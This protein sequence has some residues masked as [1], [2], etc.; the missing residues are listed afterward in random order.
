MWR[1][2]LSLLVLQNIITLDSKAQLLVGP[3]L[4]GEVSKAFF[5]DNQFRYKSLPSFGYEGG[6]MASMRVRKNFVLNAQLLYSHRSKHI[7]GKNNSRSDNLFN[8]TSSMQYLELPI[9]YVLEFKTL[10]G[11][12]TG[13]G[14]RVKTYNWFIGGGPIISYWL[15]NKGTLRSSPLKEVYI[16]HIDYTTVFGKDNNSFTAGS[17]F[18]KE[19]ISEPNRFQFGINITGGV[20]FEPVGFH[21]IVASLHLNIAQTFLGKSDGIFPASLDDIDVLKAKNHSIRLS[22]AYLFDTKL[23]TSKKGKSTKGKETQRKKRR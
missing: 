23:E 20:A 7:V 2:L 14:G 4:G 9:F 5:F 21:K 15:S 13:H 12:P 10:S 11:D 16:D 8:L 3:V 6:V 1:I 18:N 19:S 17:D 22:V